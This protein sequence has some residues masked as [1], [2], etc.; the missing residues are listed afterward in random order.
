[1][2]IT[3]SGY[4]FDEKSFQRAERLVGLKGYV[5]NI[6]VTLMPAS[7]VIGSYHELWHVEQSFRM[8]NLTIVMAALAV[9][10]YLYQ[11]TGITTKKLVRKLRPICRTLARI[12]NTEIPIDDPIPDK[13]QQILQKIPFNPHT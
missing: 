3:R 12:G 8:S 13:I 9:S 5:T 10:R 11:K 2:K 6:P 4:S 1:M 7:E